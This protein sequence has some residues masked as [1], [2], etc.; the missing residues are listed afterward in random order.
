VD[1][2]LS[3]EKGQ[4]LQHLISKEN[5]HKTQGKEIKRQTRKA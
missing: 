4:S 3:N 2:K 5:H 1:E